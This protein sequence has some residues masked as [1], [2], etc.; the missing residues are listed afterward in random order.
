[1]LETIM[2]KDLRSMLFAVAVLGGLFFASRATADAALR[3]CDATGGPVT[4]AIAVLGSGVGGPQSESEGWFQINAQTCAIVI[5]S[6]LSPTSLY[7]LYAKSGRIVWTGS[8]AAARDAQFCT[9]FAGRFTYAD[10]PAS[11]CT[12]AGEQMVWF[13]NEPATAP[14]WTVELDSP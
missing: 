11:L 12:G 6:D 10:R 1:M 5:D 8:A 9:N 13:I 4:V 7:Y 2:S 14:D 3:V